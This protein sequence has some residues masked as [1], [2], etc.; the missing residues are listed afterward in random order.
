MNCTYILEPLIAPKLIFDNYASQHG[1]GTDLARNRLE[2]FLKKYWNTYHTN[3]GYELRCDI[4]SYFGTIDRDT[5]FEMIKRLPMDEGC[6]EINWILIYSHKPEKKSGVCIGFHS[7]QWMAVYYMNGLDHFI[8]EN[9]H[10][11]W[12]GRYNDD[13]YLIH[14]DKDTLNIVMKRFANT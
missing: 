12:Y 1:K 8:K 6:L 4:K 10:I 7:M 5:L 9:L 14:P 3:E 11:K 2:K 13:F